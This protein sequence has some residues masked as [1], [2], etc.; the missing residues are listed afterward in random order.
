MRPAIILVT[1][2]ASFAMIGTA[3]AEVTRTLRV[4]LSGDVGAP[5][6][7]ENLAGAMT[8]ATSDQPGVVAV[9]TIHAESQALA[10]AVRFEQVSGVRGVPTL[11]V[12]YP[13]EHDI[14][15]YPVAGRSYVEYDGRQIQVDGREGVLVYADVE[16]QVPHR[17]LDARFKTHVGAMSARGLEG[18]LV[19][20][21]GHGAIELRQLK[22]EI[23]ADTGAGRV[24]VEDSRG[25]LRADTGSGACEVHRFEGEG[26]AC[27]TGSGAVRML[28]VQVHDI[29]ADTGA[30]SVE[31]EAP[32]LGTG[33]IKV[34]T[35]SGGVTVRLPRDASFEAHAD[36]G[37]GRITTGFSDAQPILDDDEVVG[38]RRG[39]G[40]T[41]ITVDAGSGG[42][43]IE[44][45]P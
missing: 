33:Q 42:L 8:I 43:R 19:F 9:A 5:F 12:R 40:G 36:L 28:G 22:G 13:K 11:R 4:E 45:L 15:R 23:A 29:Q 16:V 37:I 34:D 31:I 14:F 1:S 26:I 10:D 7:V 25:R 27:N 44:P 24:L 20:D 2:L 41:R 3:R 35:G 6:A 18:R 30:G 32:G 39:S 21:T 38:Y 17:T